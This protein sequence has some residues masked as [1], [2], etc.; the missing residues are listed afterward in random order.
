MCAGHL[1]SHQVDIVI[2]SHRQQDVGFANTGVALNVYIDPV[3]LN[4]LDAFEMRRAPKTTRLFIY[5][6]DL[7]ASIEKCCYSSRPNPSVSDNDYLHLVP[8]D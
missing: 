1:G 4:K 2:E 6:G 7:V 8:L 3:A 5:D